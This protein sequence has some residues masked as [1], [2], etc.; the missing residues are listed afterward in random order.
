MSS[1]KEDLLVLVLVYSFWLLLL[2]GCT[3][4]AVNST[5]RLWE[6]ILPTN[7]LQKTSPPKTSWKGWR[8]ANLQFKLKITWL[9]VLFFTLFH[10]SGCS[11]RATVTSPPISLNTPSE[12]SCTLWNGACLTLSCCCS[13]TTTDTSSSRASWELWLVNSFSATKNHWLSMTRKT[14]SVVDRDCKIA[15]SCKKRS[16]KFLHNLN[17]QYCVWIGTLYTLYLFTSLSLIPDT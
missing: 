12:P 11:E 16:R 5:N 8:L 3:D 13:C 10:T 2:N 1:P 7:L 9:R 15:T 6:N 14:E 4:S 17:A